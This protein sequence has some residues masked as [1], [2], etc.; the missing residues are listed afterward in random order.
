MFKKIILSVFLVFMFVGTSFATEFS[1]LV[2]NWANDAVV[3][4]A[5]RG[6]LSGYPDGT[7]KGNQPLTRYEMASIIARSIH[8]I[9]TTKASKKD[10]EDL[11]KLCTLLKVELDGL[12]IMVDDVNGRLMMVESRLGGWSVTGNL[13]FDAFYVD[14][15]TDV[16]GDFDG[17]GD[18][19][20]S[21][22]NLNIERWFGDNLHFYSRLALKNRNVEFTRF[23]VEFPFVWNTN[24]TVGRFVKNFED[25][26][27][28]STNSDYFVNSSFTNRVVDGLS[29]SKSTKYGDFSIY[30]AN[31]NDTNFNTVLSDDDTME[32]AGMWDIT[33][34]DH[35][36]MLLGAQ[37]LDTTDAHVFDNV[38]TAWAGVTFNL[39]DLF[40]L[41]GMY[42]YQAQKFN[43]TNDKNYSG[44]WKAIV[45]IP[46]EKLKFTSLW[47][48]YSRIDDDFVFVNGLRSQFLTDDIDSKH[49]KVGNVYSFGNDVSV[50]KVGANQEWNDK[51]SSWLFYGYYDV[52]NVD[53]ISNYALGV[54]YKV[55][56][57]TKLSLSGHYFDWRNDTLANDEWM[58]KGRVSVNF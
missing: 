32:I 44:M 30:V 56:P 29:V 19:T 14:R 39:F 31:P 3:S 51:F 5:S 42:Y 36:S 41:K 13:V 46:Q 15:T 38:L 52:E 50:I 47:V 17:D 8:F 48:E 1:D 4:M 53:K 18:I 21:K 57:N 23:Y 12:G 33:F 35:F 34:T 28:F 58:I 43:V 27:S 54:D 49:F 25:G 6:I 45:S 16:F 55:N 7:F 40:D 22:A 24:V 20:F 2:P 9:D 37:Y 26:Y 10:L 11:N